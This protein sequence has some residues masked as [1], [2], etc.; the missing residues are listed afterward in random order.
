MVD[1][2]RPPISGSEAG[3][4]M[5]G[6]ITASEFDATQ[7]SRQYA[8]LGLPS[9][10]PRVEQNACSPGNRIAGALPLSYLPLAR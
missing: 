3:A 7:V 1:L 9:I 10:S 5:Y 2:E 8:T 6:T 4:P